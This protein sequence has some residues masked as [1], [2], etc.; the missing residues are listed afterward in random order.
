MSIEA[1]LKERNIELPPGGTVAGNYV[2]TCRTGNLLFI[3]GQLPL[4]DGKVAV[5]GIVGRDVTL[6]AA[7]EGARLCA[8]NILAQAKTALGGDLEKIR[9]VV[10]LGVFVA[11][12]PDFTQQPDV[13]NG[14]SDFLVDVL[15]DR[16]RHT[17]SAVGAP[18]LP[19]NGAVE[20]DAILEVD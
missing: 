20:I 2:P 14:A 5:T 15:G 1:R 12:T 18:S 3:S 6:E 4:Q 16:G 19:R 10:K 11:S 9:R 17:R 7:R 13:G 8:I